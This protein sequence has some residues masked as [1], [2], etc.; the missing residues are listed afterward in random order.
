M[1]GERA[2]VIRNTRVIAV[3]LAIVAVAIVVPFWPALLLAVWVGALARP[4]YERAI[5]VIGG[6]RTAAA[7]LTAGLVVLIAAPTVGLVT[8]AVTEAID[9]YA[10]LRETGIGKSLFVALVSQG[11]ESNGGTVDP[12]S[13]MSLLQGYGERAWTLAIDVA[14]TAASVVIGVIVFVW[15]TYATLCDGPAKFAW[16]QHHLGLPAVAVRRLRDAFVETGRGLFIGTGV[17][18]LA[19]A[20]VATITYAVLGVPRPLLLGAITLVVS[21]VPALGPG[22]VWVP[23]ALGLLF[24]GSYGKAALLAAIGLV[25]IG[26]VDNVMRPMVAR[27]AELKLSSFVLFVS[28]LGGLAVFGPFGILLGPLAVRLAREALEIADGVT[29]GS[30]GAEPEVQSARRSATPGHSA[31]PRWTAGR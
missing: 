30:L 1:S 4:L 20:V 13:L 14:G 23:V 29:Q 19:Q 21:M 2:A 8:F 15:G 17:T 10:R 28:M 25:V 27:Y 24:A 18:S 26:S 11:S 31:T 3:V 6:R 12:R 5:G 9:L 22:I 16:M 7:V